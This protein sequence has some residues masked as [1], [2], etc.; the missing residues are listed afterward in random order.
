V[1]QCPA[2][3]NGDSACLEKSLWSFSETAHASCLAQCLAHRSVPDSSPAWTRPFSLHSS[4]PPRGF[5][6][7][8]VAVLLSGSRGRS[9]HGH[10]GERDPSTV[11]AAWTPRARAG[12]ARPHSSPHPGTKCP[13]SGPAPAAST[14]SPPLDLPL[15]VTNTLPGFSKP[16]GLSPQASSSRARR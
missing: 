1:L 15:L 3:E 9:A 14:L 12:A 10:R 6:L 8:R 13:G 11:R 2:P 4:K 7:E 5:Q 16:P